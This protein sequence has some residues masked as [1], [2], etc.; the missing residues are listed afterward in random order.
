MTMR[1]TLPMLLSA[2]LVW[3]RGFAAP[4]DILPAGFEGALQP[5]VSLDARGAIHVAFGKGTSVYHVQSKDGTHWSAPTLVGTLPK[6]AL[7]LRRGPRIVASDRTTLI[8]AISHEDG[9]VHAW[10]SADDTVWTEQPVLNTTPLSAREGLHALAGD[11]QGKVAATWLDLRTGKMSLW[12]KFSSDD[13]LHWSE[14]RLVY[15]APEGPICQCC[16]PAVAFAADGR[17]GFLWRNLLQ[18]ARDL[19]LSETTDTLRFSPAR[20]LGQ[21]TWILNA[22]PMDGGSLAYGPAGRSHPV[23]KRERTVF[24]SDDLATEAKLAQPAAQAVAAYVGDIPVTLWEANGSLMMQRGDAAP[25]TYARGGKFASI[26][27]RGPVA[28]IAFEGIAPDGH[29]TLLVELIR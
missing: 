15:A 26:Q 16:A 9:N 10:T 6:L 12:A 29:R 18:G 17:I 3:A 23:W 20:K 25:R 4:V 19:Y 28:A 8:T 14:D 27:G 7:G 5:Q 21:G 1:R 22:C 24:A 2:W 13:G 11:G